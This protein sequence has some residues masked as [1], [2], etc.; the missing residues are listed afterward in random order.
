[1]EGGSSLWYYSG[2]ALCCVLSTSDAY[3]DF[4]NPDSCR[5]AVRH[6]SSLKTICVSFLT[7]KL[8][9]LVHLTLQ[10]IESKACRQKLWNLSVNQF[11]FQ[12]TENSCGETVDLVGRS[13]VVDGQCLLGVGMVKL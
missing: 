5:C 6:H 9:L 12:E 11:H 1:M 2:K 7:C 4:S 10:Q 8:C 3:T 13:A